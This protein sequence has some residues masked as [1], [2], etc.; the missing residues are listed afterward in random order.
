MC[1]GKVCT[2]IGPVFPQLDNEVSVAGYQTSF[3]LHRFVNDLL[4]APEV[5]EGGWPERGLDYAGFC[6]KSPGMPEY[7]RDRI[8]SRG[9]GGTQPE[10]ERA[11]KRRFAPR[12]IVTRTIRGLCAVS[13]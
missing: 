1:A 13:L 12:A 9:H 2:L 3:Y 7:G 8:F 4:N 6:D 10:R 11:R 5:G